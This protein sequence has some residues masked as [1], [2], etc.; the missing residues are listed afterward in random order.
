M[1]SAIFYPPQHKVAPAPPPGIALAPGD[2]GP[3]VSSYQPNTDWQAVAAAGYKFGFVKATEGTSYVNPYF[4]QDW[5]A[6]RGAGLL[7]GAYHFAQPDSNAP[8]TEAAHFMAVVQPGPDDLMVLDL[9]VGSGDLQDWAIRFAA[10]IG[11][12]RMLY[13]GGPF[14]ANHNLDQY[15]VCVA[16]DGKLW[17]AAYGPQPP[18]PAN[19]P[20]LTFW[21]YTDGES[22]PGVAGACDC[23]RYRP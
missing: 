17:I 20:E 22:V 10:N 12:S 2:E 13:S 23:S 19:W 5:Q 21:Q 9:E 3:D 8:E 15:A 16:F 14:I 11:G 6:I 7:R 1:T 18:V 4:A